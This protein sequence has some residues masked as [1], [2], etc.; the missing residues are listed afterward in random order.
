[1]YHGHYSDCSIWSSHKLSFFR[2]RIGVW[3]GNAKK[4][5]SSYFYRY[6]SN[7]LILYQDHI[8]GFVQFKIYAIVLCEKIQMTCLM[9]I[10]PFWIN[11]ICHSLFSPFVIIRLISFRR[12]HVTYKHTSLKNSKCVLY[13]LFYHQDFFT[14]LY[15]KYMFYVSDYSIWN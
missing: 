7:A 3:A 6:N 11:L 12:W 1:M 5:T 8:Y 14:F 10:K 15:F 9:P 4:F 13:V 2:K